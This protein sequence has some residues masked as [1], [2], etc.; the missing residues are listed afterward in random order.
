MHWIVY[1]CYT[2]IINILWI[3][4]IH[5]LC[6]GWYTYVIMYWA[7]FDSLSKQKESVQHAHSRVF[8]D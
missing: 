3:Y 1:I 8:V 4:M 5:I 2:C 7:S 6:T